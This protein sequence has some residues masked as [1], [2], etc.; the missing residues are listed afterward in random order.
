MKFYA[1]LV[2][3]AVVSLLLGTLLAGQTP[4]PNPRGTFSL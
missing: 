1:S 3:C 4:A 2:V